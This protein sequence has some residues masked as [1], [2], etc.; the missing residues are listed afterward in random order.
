[1]EMDNRV[2]R[3]TALICSVLL[4]IGSLCGCSDPDAEKAASSTETVEAQSNSGEVEAGLVRIAVSDEISTLDIHQN[5]ED[6][7]VPLNIYERLF[8]IQVEEDGSTRLVKGLAEDWSTDDGLSYDFTLRE[9]A[10]FSDGSPVTA[11]DVA[12]TFTRMLALPESRQTDFA[13][14]ILGAEDLMEGKT[15]KLAGIQVRDDKHFTITLKEPYEGYLYQLATPAC[16][17]LSQR[18]V[19]KAGKAYGRSAETTMGSGPYQVTEYTNFKVVLERNPYYHC[20]EGEELSVN[21]AEFLILPPALIDRMFRQGELDLLDLN[22][23]NPETVET[24]YNS[25]EWEERMIIRNRVEVQYM[26]LNLET[27]P[28][29]DLRIRKAVQM[30]INRQKILEELFNGDGTLLDGIYP[31]GLIGFSE[32]NQGWLQYNPE[33]AAKL[34]S[35]VPEAEEFRIELAGNS[36]SEIRTL[37]MV[38]M[39]RSDLNAVGLNVSVVSYDDDSRMYLRREGVL[40]AYTGMWSADFNDPDNFI[41][42]FF[43]SRAK[44]RNRSSNYSDETVL[45]RVAE[46]RTIRNQADRMAEYAALEKLLVQDEAVWVPLFSTEHKFILGERLA[47]FTPFWAG[48][49]DL[50][51]KDIVLKP[52]AR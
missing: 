35:Q 28:L 9:D 41:Y 18:F 33:A 38:E 51:L 21:R 44:T 1:M 32:D 34:V 10:Y 47:D 2:T 14:M 40:M 16:S 23:V 49:G 19:I 43:G 30:A 24:I 46:A 52:E 17:I 48:W 8:D 50:Y 27:P 45:S 12:F 29:N 4:I 39:I 11:L 6:Y 15:T 42:T 22:R 7:M 31:R 20:R 26:M 5:T 36:Q 25:S 37:R 13:D 3:L